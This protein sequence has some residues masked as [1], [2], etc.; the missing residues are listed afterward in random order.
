[1]SHTKIALILTTFNGEKYLPEQLNSILE[2]EEASVDIFVFDDGSSDQTLQILQGFG[3]EIHITIKQNIKNSG[4]TGKNILMA[5]RDFDEIKIRDYDYFALCDQDDIWLQ[6][7]L[8]RAINLLKENS[9]SLY[10]SNLLMWSPERGILGLIK[11]NQPIKTYDYLFEGGSAGCTYVMQ[12]NFLGHLHKMFQD[13]PIEAKKRI[14]HDWLIYFLARLGKF[15][16]IFDNESKILYRIHENNQY[17]HLSNTSLKAIK[18][19]ID[20]FRKGFVY[21][22]ITNNLHFLPKNS[23]EYRIYESYTKSL[24]SR[25]YILLRYNFKLMRKKRKFLLFFIISIIFFTPFNIEKT[26]V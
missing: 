4:G 26:E 2:Q 7:K 22:Q 23:E 5:I 6:D 14:S 15:K 17:G 21:T 8:K 10:C 3:R 11:K 19:R 24:T 25:I 9:A 12:S 13:Y 1:M 16:V 20:L 18:T